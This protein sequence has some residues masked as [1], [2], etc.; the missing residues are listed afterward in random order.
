M[1]LLRGAGGNF[2]D[3]GTVTY[4]EKNQSQCH[5]FSSCLAENTLRFIRQFE[6]LMA[7]TVSVA[8]SQD[9]GAFEEPAAS[10]EVSSVGKFLSEY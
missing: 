10:V 7:V 1:P 2:I 3:R 6:L 5:R 8:V 9:T 4:S